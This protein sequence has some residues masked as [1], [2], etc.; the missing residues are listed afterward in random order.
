MP[1][2]EK[3]PQPPLAQRSSRMFSGQARMA[4][5][6]G[7]IVN[8]PGNRGETLV[9]PFAPSRPDDLQT[10]PPNDSK[11]FCAMS[12]TIY[13]ELV[14]KGLTLPSSVPHL[15]PFACFRRVL[16]IIYFHCQRAPF[17]KMP[18]PK[19]AARC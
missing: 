17:F 9:P 16:Y 13:R 7:D 2:Q 1:F 19:D 11:D 15:C 8:L 12:F 10:L 18:L 14:F 3:N 6:K 4:L 5:D